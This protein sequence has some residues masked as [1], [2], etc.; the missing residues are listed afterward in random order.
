MVVSVSQGQSRTTREWNVDP[1]A[2]ARRK[3]RLST[4]YIRD[5][6]REIEEAG[7]AGDEWP[8]RGR[9]T[10]AHPETNRVYPESPGVQSRLLHRLNGGSATGVG[11]L[12][13]RDRRE[14]NEVGRIRESG[15]VGLRTRRRPSGKKPT[16]EPE[17][18]EVKLVLG[19]FPEDL[20]RTDRGGSPHADEGRR[21]GRSVLR[22]S[23][24]CR[25]GRSRG[26]GRDDGIG[27]CGLSGHNEDKDR[28]YQ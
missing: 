10:K 4:A 2:N 17:A 14:R 8:D 18:E 23:G 9:G 25:V 28:R 5:R 1:S 20:P 21:L 13:N 3:V 19:D 6:L 12:R 26:S 22:G 15:A 7:V 11:S 27:W 24:G 16:L